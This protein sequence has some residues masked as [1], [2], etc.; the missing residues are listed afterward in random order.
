MNKGEVVTQVRNLLDDKVSAEYLWDDDELDVLVIQAYFDAIVRIDGNLDSATTVAKVPIVAGTSEYSLDEAI[1]EVF[2]AKLD[3]VD[4]PLKKETLETL[5]EY[6]TG[7]EVT[8]GTTTHYVDG[9]N[10]HKIR[11]Y[12]IPIVND[13]LSLTVSKLDDV[14]IND[15]D[16]LC[17]LPAHLHYG[18]AYL[19]CSMA[20]MKR[21]EDTFDPGKVLDFEALSE[22]YF[23]KRKSANDQEFERNYTHKKVR[24]IY[25][26]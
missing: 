3:L 17:F 20:Y 13:T 14:L 5:D 7:W 2:R 23:G 10:R 1:L 16:E 19:V 8:T 22:R 24:P 21:D 6:R 12:P 15:S 4:T 18:V 9:F 26:A 11:L 25:F